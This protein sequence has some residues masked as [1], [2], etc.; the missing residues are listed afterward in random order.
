MNT[1]LRRGNEIEAFPNN[2]FSVLL[3]IRTN[4]SNPFTQ[5][6]LLIRLFSD[7]CFDL[8][9]PGKGGSNIKPDGKVKG[10]VMHCF[11]TTFRCTTK[12][13]LLFCGC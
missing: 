10:N 4:I 6:A 12:A 2:L 3:L 7:H 13:K 8:A 11:V 9:Q 1:K 5:S